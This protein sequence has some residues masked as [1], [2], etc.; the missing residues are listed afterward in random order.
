M[1]LY[2]KFTFAV[3]SI[4]KQEI[5][6]YKTRENLMGLKI[7]RCSSCNVGVKFFVKIN[8]IYAKMIRPERI[9]LAQNKQF[10]LLYK[11][12]KEIGVQSYTNRRI[13]T[14]LISI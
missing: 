8:E 13:N 11:P 10:F 9:N 2:C 7:I 5:S 12:M 1:K 6:L 3:C 4:T 14:L